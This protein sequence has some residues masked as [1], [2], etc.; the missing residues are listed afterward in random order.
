M[1]AASPRFGVWAP[2]HG[3]R[4]AH[5]DPEEPDDAS[6]ARTRALVLEAETL[7][8]D[9]VLVAQHTMNP[10][11]EARDQ[12]DAW[13]AS[14]ALAALTHR[15]EIIAAIKPGLVH[16]VVLAK[17]ALG[18]DRISE[19]R[20][21]LNLVNAW[22]KA[23]F[24]RAG[25]PFPAHDARYAYGREWIGLVDRLM[26]GERVRFT[27]EHFRVK[28]YQLRPAGTGGRRPTL[29]VGGESE[30]ARALVADHGDVWF[31]NGQP[32]EEVAAL[33][34]D[35][36][37]RPAANG[38]LRY[39]LSAFVIA[40]DTDDEAE[41]EHARL[42]ALAE[43]DAAIRADTRARTD[44]AAVMFAKPGLAQPDGPV[45]HVGTNGGTA[46][47]LVGSYGRIAERLSAF[48]A[49]GIDLFMLQFQPFEAEMRRFAE[50]ILP[51]LR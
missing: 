36:A 1:A 32:L 40:R 20:F 16:P 37:R 6:W 31:I 3:S 33:I 13:S 12:L 48:H 7:G 10:Y 27:G 23:E 41:A 50:T 34:A 49:A 2:V 44:P 21:A 46:A 30:P 29:Y 45:R 35:V 38:P 43:R 24:E 26:R 22:N 51:R 15:I 18:I 14:A 17:A 5:H 25:L 39:G 9:S 4:A 28:D 8:F 42:I 47:G 19:G 11:D